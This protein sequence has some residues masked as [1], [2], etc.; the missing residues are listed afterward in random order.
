MHL[1]FKRS[2][3]TNMKFGKMLQ[4]NKLTLVA[5]LPANRLEMAS[6]ALEGGAQ[7][8]K[9]HINVWHRASGHT[10]GSFQDNKEFLKELVK[11]CGKV[12][13]GLVPG[14]DEAFVSRDE[15]LEMEQLGL[16]FFS[17]YANHLPCYMMESTLLDKM[18]AIDSSYNQNTLDGLVG[19][20]IDVL[21]CSIQAGENYGKPLVFGDVIRYRDISAKSPVPTLIPTQKHICPS[22]IQHL[23]AAG[24]KA[25]MVGAVVLG[26]EPTAQEVKQRT[27]QYSEAIRAL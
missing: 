17:S 10:F 1:K 22:D 14:T 9:V 2:E 20:G 11:M 6:G 24:C 21:E 27:Q 13:V 7:A 25:V 15:M 4:S 12:P 16:D 8:I 5:S 18:A 26:K 23:H 19:S 3:Y